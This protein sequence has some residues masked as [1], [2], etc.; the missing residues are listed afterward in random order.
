MT[1]LETTFRNKRVLVTGHTG[2]KGSWLCEWLLALGAEVYGLSHRGDFPL[3][4]SLGLSERI[5]HHQLGD[6][7][8]AVALQDFIQD[9][10]PD[11]AFHLAA[12]PLV[13]ASYESPVE[14]FSTNVMG[15]CHF[16]EGMRTLQ[17]RCVA[18]V[19]TTDKCYENK[20]W[21]HSYRENDAMGGKDPYSASKGA[22]ELLIASYRRSFFAPQ[23]DS[24][25][26]IASARAGNVIGGG[27][28]AENRIVP[29]CMRAL[30]DG[31]PILVR[32][33]VATRPWQHVLDPLSGY[34]KLAATISQH[35]SNDLEFLEELTSGMNFGPQ[36]EANRTVC[37]LVQEIT[38]HWPGPWES[39][40]PKGIKREAGKLALSIDK[41]FHLLD[42]GPTWDFSKSVEM[43]TRWYRAVHEGAAAIAIT[44]DQIQ[45]YAA[46][47]DNLTTTQ[48]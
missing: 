11:F 37:D 22:C 33:P 44:Q 23:H 16:L 48:P 38:Q 9:A 14:T 7:Q 46:K 39:L 45:Q 24:P 31:Q 19:I 3:F 41:A 34:L 40:P 21:L 8:N 13:L 20:E 36:T 35:S 28:W 25:I 47:L 17:K 10:Q 29:D 2:F 4:Q 42:W 30:I 5:K 18:I 43:T 27:D 15:T 6:I 26:T 1:S 12:Q 32:N